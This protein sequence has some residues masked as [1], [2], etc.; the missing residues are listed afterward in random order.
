MLLIMIGV[1]ILLVFLLQSL[2]L[3]KIWGRGLEIS[4]DFDAKSYARGDVGTIKETIV[5]RKWFPLPLVVLSFALDKSICFADEEKIVVS[6]RKYRSD[7]YALRPYAG[8]SRQFEVTFTERG[9]FQT[10]EIN[11]LSSDLFMREKYGAST[12]AGEAIYVYP[13]RMR[14]LSMDA[15]FTKVTGEY[16]NRRFIYEDPFEFKGIRDYVPTD[17]IKKINWNAFAR[18][19]QLKV[20]EYHDTRGINVTIYLNME[21]EGVAVRKFL[22]EVAIEAARTLFEDFLRKG[23]PVRLITNALD[24]ISHE[25]INV[26][27]GAGVGHLETCLRQLARIDVMNYQEGFGSIFIKEKEE[28]AEV[29]LPILVSTSQRPELIHAYED[30]LGGREGEMVVPVSNAKQCYASSPWIH[31]TYV[32]VQDV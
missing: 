4:V 2:I 31:I 15:V 17:P 18:T 23:I 19:G 6:D 22:A 20:N 28:K 29:T 14:N 21:P 7:C 16:F 25:P 12:D 1:M 5:N 24:M 10:G 9:L 26:W 3:R 27:E 32:E 8:E 13:A 30:F 11:I